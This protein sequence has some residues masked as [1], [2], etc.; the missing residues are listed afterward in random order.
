MSS[1]TSTSVPLRRVRSDRWWAAAV[2]ACAAAVLLAG[3]A[4]VGATPPPQNGV[5]PVGPLPPLPPPMLP[6]GGFRRAGVADSIRRQLGLP[7]G[8]PAGADVATRGT[9]NL[10]VILIY[11]ADDQV[12]PGSTPPPQPGPDP[13]RFPFTVDFVHDT[14]FG[15]AG[16]PDPQPTM[17]QYYRDISN[18]N[19]IL[20]GKVF[21]PYAMKHEAAYYKDVNSCAFGELLDEAL[22]QA[23]ADPRMNWAEFDN[24]ASTPAGNDGKVDTLLI[25]HSR[26]GAESVT[27][28]TPACDPARQ[29]IWSHSSQYDRAAIG[30]AQPFVTK[31]LR[32]GPNGSPTPEHILVQAYTIQPA[33][34]QS[35]LGPP[36]E[37]DFPGIGVFCH[38]YGHA[39]GLPDLYDR[40]PVAPA[41]ADSLGVGDWCLMSYG[42]YGAGRQNPW[43]P[44]P[45]CAWAKQFHGW[46]QVETI[47]ASRQVIFE[48]VERRNRIY[49]VD[50][51]GS[52]GT[53]YFLIE[54]RDPQWQPA[55]SDV[56]KINWDQELGVTGLAVWHVDE[57]VGRV[58]PGGN[59]ELNPN[60]PFT[61]PANGL[62]GQNDEPSKFDGAKHSLVAIIQRDGG[63]NF[64]RNQFTSSDGVLLGESDT[65]HGADLVM[66]CSRGYQTGLTHIA[67]KN[68]NLNAHSAF[69]DLAAAPPPPAPP[70]APPAGPAPTHQPPAPVSAPAAQPA[71]AAGPS[72]RP[73]P[74]LY[75]ASRRVDAGLSLTPREA[76]AIQKLAPSDVRRQFDPVL[77]QK[78]N[79]AAAA[80]DF[81]AQM[82]APR[83][84]RPTTATRPAAPGEEW[85]AEFAK[86]SKST[87]V[88]RRDPKTGEVLHI[89]NLD[90]AKP[91]GLSANAAADQL[92]RG[93]L[94]NVVGAKVRLKPVGPATRP[95]GSTADVVSYQQLIKVG[96]EELPV[97][98]SGVKL[99][100][101]QG[102]TL[103]DV[104]IHTTLSPDVTL[105]KAPPFD[106]AR[107]KA[108][109]TEALGL[110]K[111]A[112]KYLQEC[113]AVVLPNAGGKGAPAATWQVCYPMGKG[114]EPIHIFVDP[115][116]QKVID[117]R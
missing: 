67:I 40:T 5:A 23:D 76:E 80:A 12:P 7:A 84:A 3:A 63:M 114:Q 28:S 43:M 88:V 104:G 98:G 109:V 78:L 102:Q 30:H 90:M 37:S 95:V 19:W 26:P 83:R 54:W 13:R 81:Q 17:S 100:Y 10:P 31:T 55:G 47:T 36:T 18:G 91:E 85:I 1:G 34:R 49:R 70:A 20:S 32:P 59:G 22:K 74:A 21:G 4:P 8:A 96:D 48:P 15:R 92:V 16:V 57:N 33:L 42:M 11:F 106:E 105:P 66:P 69:V 89:G 25:I 50:V 39:L 93:D 56:K 46:A 103:S 77:A 61:D 94:A 64:E 110:P 101:E 14:L 75:T 79:A 2:V 51:P 107:A 35:V 24:D 112:A 117:V 86:P 58:L 60:W 99:Y 41:A 45:M 9:R 44:L 65:L 38:E 115:E 62:E 73:S 116:T 6:S 71:A 72:T 111:E 97:F 53:E 29:S 87:P 108:I 68:I 82:T 113:R 52:N 27:A